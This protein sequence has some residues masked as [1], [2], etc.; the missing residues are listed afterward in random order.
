MRIAFA[1]TPE[2][3]VAPFLALAASHHEISFAITR[4]DAKS[5]RGRELKESAIAV[6]A[7]NHGIEVLKPAT[8]SEIADRLSDV[9]LVVVVAYGALIPESL[10][11]VPKHGWINVHYSLLPTWR[12]AAPVQHAIMH[13]DDVTGVSI[14]QIDRSLDTGPVYA[15]VT[16]S[17]SPTI[18]ATQ[19]LELLNE[20]ASVLVVQVIDALEAG[21][22]HALA[23][24]SVDVSYAPKISTSDA[25]ID[26]TIPALAVSRRIRAV[27]DA[28]GAWSM[29]GEERL[30]IAPVLMRTD[31]T[32]LAPGHITVRDSEVLVG[33]GT[34]AVQLTNIQR[35]G[36]TF[37]PAHSQA[38][39]FSSVSM[40]T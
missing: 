19:V 6:A 21:K 1:G 4:P 39:L 9:D 8:L 13:G 23:Q 26:W 15:T 5:G 34:H 28:P 3:A 24:S 30:K 29:L 11:S 35:A 38:T 32:D 40:F 18:T 37:V 2:S 36:K 33:T 22:I 20:M 17:L 25:R 10:L 31:V 7:H 27:T 14:F 16:T 12:G